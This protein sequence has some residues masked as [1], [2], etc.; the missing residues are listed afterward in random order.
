MAVVASMAQHDQQ[1]LKDMI[2]WTEVRGMTSRRV[3]SFLTPVHASRVT[4]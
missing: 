1:Y 2:P 3:D 4:T